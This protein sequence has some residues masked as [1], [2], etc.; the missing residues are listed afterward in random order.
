MLVRAL[1]RNNTV[2][3]KGSII[4]NLEFVNTFFGIKQNNIFRNKD[5]V[6]KN[7]LNVTFFTKYRKNIRINIDM[8][9]HMS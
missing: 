1:T 5:N 6:R 3:Y 8:A 9:L 2:A 4:Q 7:A